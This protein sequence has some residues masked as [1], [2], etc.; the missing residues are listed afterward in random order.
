[1]RKVYAF[2]RSE[3]TNKVI[4]DL[5]E[6]GTDESHDPFYD[7]LSERLSSV[8]SRKL[9]SAVPHNEIEYNSCCTAKMKVCMKE[10][11]SDTR[12]QLKT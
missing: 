5:L 6:D 7:D 3:E 2:K 8:I 10:L 1:M 12:I 9:V 11:L 4:V